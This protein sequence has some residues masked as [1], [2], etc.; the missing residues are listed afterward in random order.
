MRTVPSVAGV[1]GAIGEGG[2]AVGILTAIDRGD[3]KTAIINGGLRALQSE[4]LLHAAAEFTKDIAPVT[5]AISK[6]ADKL[7]V[8]GAVIT[9][10]YD[11]IEVAGYLRDAY[12]DR[13]DQAKMTKDLERAALATVAG[14]VDVGSN[15]ALPPGV[16][17]AVDTVVRQSLAEV[18]KKMGIPIND[19]ALVTAVKGAMAL[20]HKAEGAAS[21]FVAGLGKPDPAKIEA[22]QNTVLHSDAV[23]PKEVKLKGKTVP[24]ATALRDPAFNKAF[25]ENLQAAEKGG[26]LEAKTELAK[27]DQFDTLERQRDTAIAAASHPAAPTQTAARAPA[28]TAP[29][30][31]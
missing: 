27:I 13:N 5:N 11:G 9:G 26:H 17:L 6:V 29:A 4:T 15:L 19:A 3:W 22:E 28:H 21:K 8:V 1:S 10:V 16:G 12:R 14:I 31:A 7:P 20:E 25:R 30:H 24:L 18:S 23:L 2:L